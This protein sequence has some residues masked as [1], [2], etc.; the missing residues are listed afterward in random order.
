VLVDGAI[1]EK[2]RELRL[3]AAALELEARRVGDI[4]E[5]M[6]AHPVQRAIT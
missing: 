1:A 5:W 2:Q 6:R 4:A 3:H